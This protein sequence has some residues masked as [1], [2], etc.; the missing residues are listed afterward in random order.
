MFFDFLPLGLL[1]RAAL[2][3]EQ[4]AFDKAWEDLDEVKDIVAREMKIYYAD[5]HLEASRLSLA[6][7]RKNDAKKY[8]SSAKI[9]IEE[10][11]YHRRKV[12][13]KMLEGEI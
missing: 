4:G 2:H 9:M 7:G 6:E 12:D 1:A 3:R 13:V 5:Y 8:L 10:M 11:G